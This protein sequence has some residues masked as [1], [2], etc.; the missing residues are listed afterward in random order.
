MGWC[1][2]CGGGVV[3][4]G[5]AFGS[6]PRGECWGGGVCLSVFL[7]GGVFGGCWVWGVLLL[8]WVWRGG[9]LWGGSIKGEHGCS[10]A[11]REDVS[12]LGLPKGL[13]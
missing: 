1:S 9:R 10:R 2:G 3:E 12:P 8:P 5:R 13:R 4:R 11:R 6:V 7:C